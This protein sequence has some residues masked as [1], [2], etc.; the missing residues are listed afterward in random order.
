MRLFPLLATTS[1][2]AS[3]AQAVY[4]PPAPSQSTASTP[5]QTQGAASYLS[6]QPTPTAA[7][8]RRCEGSE[9]C[10]EVT[11]GPQVP[12]AV[13]TTMMT[14]KLVPCTTTTTVIDSQTQTLTLWSTEIQTSTEH[15]SGVNTVT[16]WL[17]TPAPEIKSKTWLQVDTFT[18]VKTGT[19]TSFWTE[20]QA[21][22]TSSST[23]TGA[24]TTWTDGGKQ[25]CHGCANAQ[26]P[27]T[28]T[29]SSPPQYAPPPYAP[30]S[31]TTP[32]PA[33]IQTTAVG[34]DGFST[35]TVAAVGGPVVGGG[36]G[37]VPAPVSTTPTVSWSG[38]GENISGA[39]AP[40]GNVDG[41]AA[42]PPIVTGPGIAS[43]SNQPGPADAPYPSPPASSNA[44]G[45]PI[46][47]GAEGSASNS[48]G[49]AGSGTAVSSPFGNGASGNHAVLSASNII[50]LSGLISLLVSGIVL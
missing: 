37:P 10:A 23:V 8:Q 26:P 30:P 40:L 16:V 43:M 27:G 34:A 44:Q 50:G 28:V 38:N 18:F 20:T 17:V 5:A 41:A 21:P 36:A 25:D 13:T 11:A 49:S 46:Q 4:L 3:L 1:T 29:V 15:I 6:P 2:L 7:I 32:Q 42:G 19:A 39:G 24:A 14:T 47:Q 9:T 35:P 22:Q 33:W 12:I 31:V 45:V 48:T